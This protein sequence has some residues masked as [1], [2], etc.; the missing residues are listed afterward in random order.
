[1]QIIST[2]FLLFS[3]SPI[4]HSAAVFKLVAV[5]DIWNTGRWNC[6]GL[7]S[8]I[9]WSHGCMGVSFYNKDIWCIVNYVNINSA[10]CCSLPENY[11][12]DWRHLWPVAL[13]TITSLRQHSPR[14]ILCVCA[15]S[16]DV[17]GPLMCQPIRTL[18]EW[19][20]YGFWPCGLCS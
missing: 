4:W 10:C 7:L 19:I 18:T 8:W 5:C 13:L 12:D 15:A 9:H 20:L 3:C 1:M 2:A 11:R 14:T 16:S 6:C 17:Y